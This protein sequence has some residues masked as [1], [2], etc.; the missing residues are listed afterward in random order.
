[1][2]QPE[3]NGSSREGTPTQVRARHGQPGQGRGDSCAVIRRCAGEQ[4]V[5]VDRPRAVPEVDETGD[6]LEENAFL[7][8]LALAR[9]DRASQRSQTTRVSRSPLSG[10]RP[11]CGRR[12]TRASTRPTATTSRSSCASSTRAGATSPGERTAAISH[13]CGGGFPGR[14]A[15]RCRRRHRGCISR[16]RPQGRRVRLRPGLLSRHGGDGRTFARD[17]VCREARDL[18]PREG[19]SELSPPA[20]CRPDDRRR[21]QPRMSIG[22]CSIT[23]SPSVTW[24][25][26]V[27]GDRR[28]DVSGSHDRIRVPTG[29]G[30]RERDVLV[31]AEPDLVTLDRSDSRGPSR[32]T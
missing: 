10:E 15:A 12:A 3:M 5:L 13:C 23:S 7:K 11:A 18:P 9:R 19:L 6:T 22:H 20:S 30:R 24:R 4:I 27:V 31:G 26:R 32:V 8:A 16:S 2:S 25:V 17:V 21:H 14:Q 28:I 1:M 29:F